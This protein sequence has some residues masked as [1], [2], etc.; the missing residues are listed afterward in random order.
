VADAVKRGADVAERRTDLPEELLS[1]LGG[2]DAPR[3]PGEQTDAQP[4]TAW[5]RAEVETPSRTA[6]FVKLRSSATAASA[7]STSRLSCVTVESPST[8]YPVLFSSERALPGLPSVVG[9]WQCDDHRPRS[10]RKSPSEGRPVSLN[11]VPDV[12]VKLMT[13]EMETRRSLGVSRG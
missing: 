1:R 11:S 5:L 2:R 4:R 8:D 12:I 3:R 10:Q 9:G 13:P 6:A 7:D